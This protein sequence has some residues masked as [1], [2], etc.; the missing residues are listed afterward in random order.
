MAALIRCHHHL[1]KEEME[2]MTEDEFCE[3]WGQTKYYLEIIH[4][5]KFS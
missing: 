5:V 3:L 4:Q 2:Q 1:K